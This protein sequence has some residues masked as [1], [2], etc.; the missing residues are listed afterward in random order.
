MR[1]P[2]T[3]LRGLMERQILPKLSEPIRYSP[4]FDARVSDLVHSVKVQA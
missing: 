4:L 3:K 2:L 1:E